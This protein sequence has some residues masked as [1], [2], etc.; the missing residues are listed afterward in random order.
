MT[1]VAVNLNALQDGAQIPLVPGDILR[2]TVDFTYRVAAPITVILWAALGTGL[3][4]SDME[5]FQ[6]LT[7]D[8]AIISKDIEE[9]IDINIPVE[10]EE[11]GVYWLQVEIRDYD[12]SDHI[13]DAVVISGMPTDIWDTMA[14][15]MPLM[16]MMMLMNMI[17][18]MMQP[19]E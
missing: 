16:L 2:I 8:T 4:R 17:M 14:A 15:I 11:N 12:A 19:T 5:T 18:P 6:E 1:V 7:L 10:G 13:D 9:I 3:L